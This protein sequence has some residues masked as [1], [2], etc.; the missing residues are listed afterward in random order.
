QADREAMKAKMAEHRKE[1]LAKVES[2]LT[3]EQ[4]AIWKELVGDPFEIK[5]ER[6]GSH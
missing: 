6:P 3:D 5:W 4:K 2:K 1:T